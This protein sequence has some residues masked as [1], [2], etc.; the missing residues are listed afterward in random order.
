MTMTAYGQ[1]ENQTFQDVVADGTVE[2]ILDL[3][4]ESDTIILF[5]FEVDNTQNDAVVYVK[6]Y[7]VETITVGTS[8]PTYILKVPASS[9]R[10]LPVGGGAGRKFTAAATPEDLGF[11]V[12]TDPGTG[13]TTG[14]TNDV[15]V[16]AK[17]D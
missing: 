15:E 16:T 7:F 10:Y 11:V 1:L 14:P 5:G 13:G 3:A 17:T 2:V 12:V 4:A 6:V 9:K 8:L